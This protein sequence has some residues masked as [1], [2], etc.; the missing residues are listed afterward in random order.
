MAIFTLIRDWFVSQIWGGVDSLGDSYS[1]TIGDNLTNQSLT[2]SIGDI[3]IGL[4]DWLSTTSTIIVV[5]L[6]CVAL[7]CLLI[8]LFRLFRGLFALRG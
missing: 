1:A 5:A 4:G 3:S 2:F 6:L 8:G 7:G